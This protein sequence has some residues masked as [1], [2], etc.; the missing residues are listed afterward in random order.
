M[1][2]YDLVEARQRG[3]AWQRGRA[4]AQKPA[5]ALH[6][7]WWR[8][9][10]IHHWRKRAAEKLTANAITQARTHPAERRNH[11]EVGGAS[12][13]RKLHASRR[14]ESS[15]LHVHA[16]Q[17][18]GSRSS[19]RPRNDRQARSDRRNTG[20]RRVTRAWSITL[21]CGRGDRHRG[22]GRSDGGRKRSRSSSC[23]NFLSKLLP[24]DL[25]LAPPLHIKRLLLLARE[26]LLLKLNLLHLAYN[27]RLHWRRRWRSH[28][29]EQQRNKRFLH[30]GI[31]L[32]H[33]LRGYEA[34]I[35]RR[36]YN[37]RKQ[38]KRLPSWISA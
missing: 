12:K 22:Q 18:R 35:S 1:I 6:Q 8:K 27:T 16:R 19:S 23:G 15:P 25:S 9:A 24:Q 17:P 38:N 26:L 4:S 30:A 37:T 20:P 5:A 33:E 34:T 10:I 29:L 32:S 31:K 11:G 28:A 2:R 13:R 36:E 7:R 3:R 14:R 21:C